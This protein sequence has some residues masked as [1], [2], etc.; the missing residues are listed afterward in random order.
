MIYNTVYIYIQFVSDFF[1]LIHKLDSI[2]FQFWLS[3]IWAAYICFILILIP[4]HKLAL[5]LIQILFQC[6]LISV[7][8]AI[9]LIFERYS[10]SPNDVNHTGNRLQYIKKYILWKINVII[11]NI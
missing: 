4:I 5:Y 9:V 3:L 2:C 1:I 8:M 7:V 10:L 11:L 6:N